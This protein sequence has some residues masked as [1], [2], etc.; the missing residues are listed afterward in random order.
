MALDL[1]GGGL[2]KFGLADADALHALVGRH[3]VVGR[4]D[5]LLD[6][7]VDL[8]V[9][10]VAVVF[11]DLRVVRENLRLDDDALLRAAVDA[12]DECFRDVVLFT[13]RELDFLREDVLAVLGDDD[14]L[15]AAGHVQETVLVEVTDVAGVEPA[16]LDDL[17]GLFRIVE[18]AHHDGRTA[19]DDL[20]VAGLIH[21]DDLDLGAGHRQACGCRFAVSVFVDRDDRRVLRHAVALEDREAHRLEV[22]DDARVDRRAADD[23]MLDLAAELL[24][25]FLENLLADERLVVHLRAP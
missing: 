12:V 2:F 11:L 3:L 19:A 6:E 4:V 13:E 16:V 5:G 20:A 7:L 21:I 10:Q 24:V 8:F 15:L 17:G 14:A 18:V 22:L 23:E 1:A 25:N 9:G